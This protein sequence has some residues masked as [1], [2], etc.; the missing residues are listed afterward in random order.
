[1]KI[2]LYGRSAELVQTLQ[3][4]GGYETNA[5]VVRKLINDYYSDMHDRLSRSGTSAVP[6]QSHIG[7]SG[8]QIDTITIKTTHQSPTEVPQIKAGEPPEW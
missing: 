4:V 3:L 7:T 2:N 5:A 6:R 1:M 8:N